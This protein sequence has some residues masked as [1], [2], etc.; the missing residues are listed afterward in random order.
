MGSI[1]NTTL[2]PQESMPGQS[3]IDMGHVRRRGKHRQ[4][5]ARLGVWV[6]I[7]IWTLFEFGCGHQPRPTRLES[8]A[9]MTIRWEN[10]QEWHKHLNDMVNQLMREDILKH[11]NSGTIRVDLK[12]SI[13]YH[14][15][16]AQ[17]DIDAEGDLWCS[18][19]F[20]AQPQGKIEFL[21]PQSSPIDS[22]ED[23]FFMVPWVHRLVNNRDSKL[24][25]FKLQLCGRNRE[26]LWPVDKD[27]D[28]SFSSTLPD[29]FMESF[30][31]DHKRYPL[32]IHD[33]IL[34]YG[35]TL[36]PSV[37]RKLSD[38]WLADNGNLINVLQN[39]GL[40]YQVQIEIFAP[41]GSHSVA[42]MKKLQ[43]LA[44]DQKN[45]LISDHH[46][47]MEY[48]DR[49]N[50]SDTLS[51]PYTEGALRNGFVVFRILRREGVSAKTEKQPS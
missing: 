39:G 49:N 5:S 23:D 7:M 47:L 24:F 26:S 10:G 32:S 4:P 40:Y 1:S 42:E 28:L 29:F 30:R 13:C 14:D 21:N 15:N 41:N 18:M 6:A 45:Y 36:T 16:Y 43:Q 50:L 37:H 2:P 12:Y 51:N 27:I 11:G 9:N 44:M 38:K 3:G 17:A 48:F 8:E 33:E 19:D 35:D 25:F 31:P 22:L 34:D 46:I 20:Q